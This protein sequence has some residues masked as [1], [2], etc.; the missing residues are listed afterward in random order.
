MLT[1]MVTNSF[2]IDGMTLLS[3][4]AKFLTLLFLVCLVHACVYKM[5]NFFANEPYTIQIFSYFTTYIFLLCFNMDF[6]NSSYVTI[7]TNTEVHTHSILQ[8]FHTASSQY[9]NQM[10]LNLFHSFYAIT[11]YFL[12]DYVV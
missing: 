2:I 1:K 3:W 12:L 9:L 10:Q 11:F 5:Q 7:M 6:S 4:V 8:Q